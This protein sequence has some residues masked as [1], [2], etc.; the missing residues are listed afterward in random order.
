[1]EELDHMRLSVAKADDLVVSLEL[2]DGTALP[3]LVNSIL[4]DSV[5][6]FQTDDARDDVGLILVRN[7]QIESVL[8]RGDWQSMY[9]FYDEHFNR[10]DEYHMA[11]GK[12]LPM[13]IRTLEKWLEHIAQEAYKTPE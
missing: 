1:M 7:D 4:T 9:M 12:D 11:V 2:T 6:V 8:V 5:L 10:I 13:P 3:A